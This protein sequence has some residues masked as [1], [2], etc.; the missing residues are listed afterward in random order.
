[1]SADHFTIESAVVYTVKSKHG[2]TKHEGL[3]KLEDHIDDLLGAYIDR[4]ESI[5]TGLLS[6]D[7]LKIHDFMM[8]SYDELQTIFA[9]KDKVN[10]I[11]DDLKR[12]ADHCCDGC[13]ICCDDW[14]Q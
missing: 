5:R 9:L 11:K 13:E 1:M 14:N 8:G 10:D 3:K 4:M 6:K 2:T 7:K 12:A